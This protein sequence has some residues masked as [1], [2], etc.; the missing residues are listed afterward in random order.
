MSHI[1]KV[2]ILCHQRIGN[3]FLGKATYLPFRLELTVLE[4]YFV[5]RKVFFHRFIHF[6]KNFC[7]LIITWLIMVF[8]YPDKI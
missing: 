3:F 5:E 2:V 7:I 4:H 6:T 8:C 1:I